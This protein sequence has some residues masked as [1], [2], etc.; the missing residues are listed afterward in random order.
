MNSNL[1]VSI[2]VRELLSD[3]VS[4]A[5]DG[6]T[7]VRHSDRTQIV[8]QVIDYAQ[9]YGLLTRVRDL[10]LELTAL[11]V[12]RGRALIEQPRDEVARTV[13]N[14]D[15]SAAPMRQRSHAATRCSRRGERKGGSRVRG[16]GKTEGP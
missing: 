5:F 1:N 13:E 9:L 15:D 4:P 6:L 8:G 14:T 2:T 7:L 12:G 3:R 16:D 10:G 11:T